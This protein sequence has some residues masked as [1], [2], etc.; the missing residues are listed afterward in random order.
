M[1]ITVVSDVLGKENNGTTIAAMN[2]IRALKKRG[3]TVRVLC[4]DQNRKGQENYYVCPILSLGIFNN[5]V[6]KNGVQLAKPDKEVVRSALQGVD[7]VHIMLPFGLGK[8]ALRMAQ[9]MGLPITAGF[10]TQAENI[11]SHLF[12]KNE[13]LSNFIVYKVFYNSFYRYVDAIHYPTEFI[14]QVFEKYS[15]HKTNAYV[16][17]NGVN[18][19]FQ[20]RPDD[21]K[22]PAELNGNYVILST[23][24][25]SDEKC[26]KV[27]IR[28]VKKSR[29]EKDIQLVLAG[30]GPLEKKYRHL[31]QNLTNKPIM[32]F[33]DHET[34]VNVIYSA[35]L[36]CHPADIE[37]ESI[38]CLE[39]ISGGLVPL[40][41]NSHRSAA[42]HFALTPENT[43]KVNNVH[44]LANQIDYWIEHPEKKDENRKLYEHFTDQFAF[45]TCMDRMEE[46]II[47]TA[48]KK[49]HQ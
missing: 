12:L 2:L 4:C 13:K 44:D 37:I 11:T 15:G 22:R 10:H 5:Y 43:F 3:H 29:H 33:F 20:K 23:G 42:R 28:A 18:L 9:K 35:D 40:I 36:Y 24:R 1:I 25:Y 26:Q 34:M 49:S 21:F 48:K 16:I 38:A 41:S 19:R 32:R 47:S 14:H 6:A 30:A 45:E 39:A 7:A 17:S 8:S 46:M 31:G 27:L